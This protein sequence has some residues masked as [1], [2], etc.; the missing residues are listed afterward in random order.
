DSPL[1]VD[2]SAPIDP[3]T[4]TPATVKLQTAA[5]A[6]VPRTFDFDRDGQELLIFPAATLAPSTTY[7]LDISGLKVAAQPAELTGQPLAPFS[8]QFTTISFGVAKIYDY[9]AE[10]LGR[11][12]N[13]IGTP[14]GARAPDQAPSTTV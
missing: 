1:V 4:V 8:G 3:R 14:G 7:K 5:G 10:D 2:F 6:D 9:L 11:A 13:A 12:S